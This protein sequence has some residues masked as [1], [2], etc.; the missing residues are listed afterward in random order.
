MVHVRIGYDIHP[1]GFIGH[2]EVILNHPGRGFKR[3]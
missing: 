2:G 3:V 1:L